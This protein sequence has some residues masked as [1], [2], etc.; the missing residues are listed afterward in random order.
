MLR[1]RLWPELR[2]QPRLPL[3]LRYRGPVHTH[4]VLPVVAGNPEPSDLYMDVKAVGFLVLRVTRAAHTWQ[5]QGNA[6]TRRANYLQNQRLE[7]ALATASTSVPMHLN[8]GLARTEQ[9]K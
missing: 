9:Y 6:R 4:Y 3:D 1:I 5:R 2:Q 8:Q 7:L